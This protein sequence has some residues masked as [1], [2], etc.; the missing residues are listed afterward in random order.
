MSIYFYK[1]TFRKRIEVIGNLLLVI[2]INLNTENSKNTTYFSSQI[3]IIT[4][5]ITISLIEY[6]N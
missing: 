6:Y 5:L 1:G 3:A 4:E 2:N